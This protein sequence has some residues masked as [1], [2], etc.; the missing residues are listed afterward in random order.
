MTWSIWGRGRGREGV[1][2]KMMTQTWG[3]WKKVV[4]EGLKYTRMYS[5]PH[6]EE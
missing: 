5:G 2:E 4:G 3:G 6:E 1:E